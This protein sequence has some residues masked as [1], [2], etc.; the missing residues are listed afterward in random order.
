MTEPVGTG[1]TEARPTEPGR[2][3]TLARLSAALRGTPA[4]QLAGMRLALRLA[5]LV[6]AL[7]G[8]PLGL[9]YLLTRPAPLGLP[10]TA[11]LALTALLLGSGTLWLARRAAVN[12]DIPH[13]QRGLSAVPGLPE[14]AE[15]PTLLAPPA[16]A[17]PA[18][19][20]P[21]RVAEPTPPSPASHAGPSPSETRAIALALARER[22][23][24]RNADLCEVCGLTHQQAW[25]VLRGLVNAGLLRRLGSGTRDAYYELGEGVGRREEG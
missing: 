16:A 9:L 10:V 4:E 20:A 11:G 23:R 3:G 15:R 13:E 5:F 21:R 22:G 18:P 19:A 12:P 14:P 2:P 1:P 17:A 8:L 25:R 6:L 24:V 7:P